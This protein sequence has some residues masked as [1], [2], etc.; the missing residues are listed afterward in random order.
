MN[1]LQ[2]C[3]ESSSDNWINIITLNG[4]I[5]LKV[6]TQNIDVLEVE[7]KRKEKEER[8]KKEV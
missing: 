3:K 4:C 2:N 1:S 8:K 7:K 6:L 5:C